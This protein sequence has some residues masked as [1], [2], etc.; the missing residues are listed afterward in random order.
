MSISFGYLRGIF[1]CGKC[2]QVLIF[3]LELELRNLVKDVELIVNFIEGSLG[4]F[5]LSKKSLMKLL[6]IE[7]IL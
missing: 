1:C 4:V 2:R 5:F 7:C 6:G 3:S